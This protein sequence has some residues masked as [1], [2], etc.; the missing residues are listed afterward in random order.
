MSNGAV[1][2]PQSP[3]LP[4]DFAELNRLG[5]LSATSS[6]QRTDALASSEGP[7]LYGEWGL[8]VAR[9]LPEDFVPGTGIEGRVDDLLVVAG[10][11]KSGL[12]LELNQN[13][14]GVGVTIYQGFD[15]RGLAVS[16]HGDQL[17][18]ALRWTYPAPAS[19]FSRTPDVVHSW[20]APYAPKAYE[21]PFVYELPGQEPTP[22]L[23][24]SIS[25]RIPTFAQS[26]TAL[27][28]DGSAYPATVFFSRWRNI[29]GSS[30]ATPGLGG[31]VTS[32]QSAP[33]NGA[34]IGIPP[35]ARW[36]Q[37]RLAPGEPPFAPGAITPNV[38]GVWHCYG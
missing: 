1:A 7:S 15:R 25:L 9:A 18:A 2:R 21:V 12:E 34:R 22:D 30:T 36:V 10:A 14:L 23:I 26:L 38:R 4:V 16:I 27:R 20:V 5:Q 6:G 24:P 11:D 31:L 35:W 33:Q 8:F 17:R 19:R 13:V 28:D 37:F 32:T 3:G 29:F